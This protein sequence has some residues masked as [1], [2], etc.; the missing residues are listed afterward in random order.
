[1]KGR[2]V[3]A[4]GESERGVKM[5]WGERDEGKRSGAGGVKAVG[6]THKGSISERRW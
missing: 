2:G 5:G 1:M 3:G 4:G 6:T